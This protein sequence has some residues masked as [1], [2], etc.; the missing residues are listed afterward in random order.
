MKSYSL[1]RDDY[2]TDSAALT[3]VLSAAQK[4]GTGRTGIFGLRLQR[5]SFDFFTQQLRTLYPEPQSDAARIAAAFGPVR[6]IHLTRP[7]KLA[8]A[9]SRVKAEQTGLWH[10]A[11]DGSEMERLAPPQQ[12]YY[13]AAAIARHIAEMTAF[14][15][16]WRDWFRRDSIRPLQIS[17]DAL[18][19]NPGGVLAQVLEDLGLDASAA[20][21][22]APPTAKL[23]DD[24]SKAWAD[25]FR[26][27]QGQ[28]G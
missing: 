14:D 10:R 13:D 19:N 24:V 7:D 22:I 9:I 25:R 20:E 8:Q 17:Y 11:A 6:Y 2:T 12:P 18:A 4:R 1:V 15:T 23:S 3:A 5:G 26:A 28:E 16:Q 27:E 21:G